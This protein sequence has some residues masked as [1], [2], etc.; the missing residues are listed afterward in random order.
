MIDEPENKDDELED[1]FMRHLLEEISKPISDGP[2][3]YF[4]DEQG[5]L[6]LSTE[7]V[8]APGFVSRTVF[9]LSEGNDGD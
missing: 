8:W 1:E 5:R 3:G 2:G 9:V 4:R 7:T 6:C